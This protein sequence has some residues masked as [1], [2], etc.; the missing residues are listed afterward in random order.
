MKEAVIL[1]G[2]TH[3]NSKSALCLPEVLDDDG[4][5][6]K[7]NLIQEWLWYTWNK[8]IKDIKKVI[9][10]KYT[11]V[12]FNGDIADLDS[13][14]RS[15]QMVSRNPAT[16]L[17]MTRETLEPITELADRI[18]V[19]RGTEAHVGSSG[20]IEEMLAESLGAEPN[21]EFGQASWW[22]LRAEFSGVKFDI[23]HHTS[24]GSLPYTYPNSM[25]RLIQV[26][27]LNYLEW[28][29]QPP[30]V[31]VRAHNH[32]HV[33][34]GTTFSTRGVNLPAWQFQ[35]SYLYRL[36]KENDRPHIGASLFVCDN[37]EH[38]YTP[39]IYEPKRSPAWIR[40]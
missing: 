27:R 20:W 28:G 1:V 19:I 10:K 35:N 31:I 3:I 4:D 8:C 18:F 38:E 7:G 40:K 16:I 32:R 12:V 26:T 33:D 24:M 11:T 37:G 9:K 23:A 29:E 2:D 17:R 34:T 14:K 39:F 22:H 15:S 30:D 25:T 5:I 6:Y 21:K 36:G 13:K